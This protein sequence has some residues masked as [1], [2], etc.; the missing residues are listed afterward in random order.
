[1]N[2]CLILL[3]LSVAQPDAIGPGDH[4]RTIMMGEQKRTVIA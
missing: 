3:S 2:A 1:M 4:T